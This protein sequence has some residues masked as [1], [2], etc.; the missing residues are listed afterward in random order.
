VTSPPTAYS[1]LIGEEVCWQDPLDAPYIKG[2]FVNGRLLVVF[3]FL[4]LVAPAFASFDTVSAAEANENG[5]QSCHEGIEKF[6]DGP[7]MIA[8][9]AMATA[10]RDPGGWLAIARVAM[11][12]Q[13]RWV[14]ASKTAGSLEAMKKDL[15]LIWKR[16]PVTSFPPAHRFSHSPF[17]A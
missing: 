13:K 2:T 9:Q 6:S 1:Y 17:Q 15:S 7:M 5:C 14:M 4:G 8:I 11:P 16:R 3:I 12:I 10:Y